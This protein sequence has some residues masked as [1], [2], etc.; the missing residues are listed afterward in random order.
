MKKAAGA[1]KTRPKVPDYC[2]VEPRRDA[3]GQPIWPA[4]ATAIEQAREWIREWFV[5]LLAFEHS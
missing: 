2:D 1:G 3:N 5:K 4:D